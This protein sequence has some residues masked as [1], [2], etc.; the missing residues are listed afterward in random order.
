[1]IKYHRGGISLM[2]S[3]CLPAPASA[4]GLVWY[5][6]LRLHSLCVSITLHCQRYICH[7]RQEDHT[8]KAELLMAQSFWRWLVSWEPVKIWSEFF[9]Y[10]NSWD[11]RRDRWRSRVGQS[12]LTFELSDWYHYAGLC[13]HC[14]VLSL[15]PQSWCGTVSV[16]H[17]RYRHHWMCRCGPRLCRGWAGRMR[18]RSPQLW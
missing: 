8:L 10:P 15:S 17:H 6:I 11:E 5:Q 7:R 3:S 2:Y 12:D 18:L 9:F 13:F 1:M 16:H 14:T 4:S